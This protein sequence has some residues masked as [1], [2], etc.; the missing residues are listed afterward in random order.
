[1]AARFILSA[2]LSLAFLTLTFTPL[3]AQ[4]QS[5]GLSAWRGISPAVSERYPDNPLPAPTD[6]AQALSSPTLAQSTILW[7]GG[8]QW[9]VIGWNG[10]G[11]A[12]DANNA[13]LLF[14]NANTTKP[15]ATY[16]H[17]PPNPANKSNHYERSELYH[18]MT[19]FYSSL[20]AREKRGGHLAWRPLAGNSGG[21]SFADINATNDT[22]SFNTAAGN[23]NA[24]TYMRGISIRTTFDNYAYHA[25]RTSGVIGSAAYTG[26]YHPDRVAGTPIASIPVWPLS[27]AEASLLGNSIRSYS[28]GAWWLRSPGSNDRAA[29]VSYIGAISNSGEYLGLYTYLVRPALRVNLTSVLFTSSTNAA[30]AK[31]AVNV[32]DGLVGVGASAPTGAPLKFTLI[33]AYDAITNQTV[34]ALNSTITSAGTVQAGATVNIP[35]TGATTGANNFVSAVITN[36]TGVIL[37]YGKLA[38]A[39]SASGTASFTVPAAAALP[40]GNYTIRLFVEEANGDNA[41][42]FASTP[43][44]IAMT[45]ANSATVPVT[46]ITVTGAGNATTITTNGGTLQMAAAVTPGNASNNTVT[47]SVAP[48]GVATIN[49]SGL[50][51][52]TGNGTVTVTAT[53]TDG[54]GISGSTTIT[55]S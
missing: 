49:A 36:N 30:S 31:S 24:S 46:G 39:N 10:Q 32:G 13:T 14:A 40:N 4:A 47:W 1:M 20:P 29:Y 21:F 48:A 28:N 45:V 5:V 51:T 42:D 18:A 52:A 3:P 15:A 27:V 53:A 16:F 23:A 55:I 19:D 41:T 37:F 17:N 33:D 54:S 12:S 8:Y 11:V 43:I 2:F 35:Y 25:L 7:F 38:A 22:T 50:L 9:V 34:L 6:S 26:T 44:D